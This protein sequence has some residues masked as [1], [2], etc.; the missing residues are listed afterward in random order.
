MLSRPNYNPDILSCLANLSSDEVFTPPR[1]VNEMLDLLPPEIWR[2][3]NVTFLDPVCKTGVFL[4]EIA[5]RLDVG[6]EKEIPDRQQRINHIFGKQLFGIGI[7]ELTT[8]LS[9]RSVYCSKTAN[10]KYSVCETFDDPRGNI[11]LERTEHIWENGRCAFCGASQQEY[12]RGN[13]LET[14]AY[15]F[16]HTETP[17]EIFRMKFDVIVG[18]P[19]YQL[20]DGG[21]QKSASPIYH[22]FVE[23]S[24]K[25]NPRY[26]SMI[27]PARWYAGGKGLD[28][29]R[30]TILND[31]RM[32]ILHDFPETSDC[33][34]GINIRGGVC[35]FLWEK[36][37]KGDCQIISH[38]GNEVTEPIKRPLLEKGSE[39]FI[40]YND[41]IP[42][43]RKVSEHQEDS[44]SKYVSAHKAFGLR[45]YVKGKEN[46]FDGSVK[47]YQNGGIGYIKREDVVKNTQWIDKWKIV[48]PYASPGSDVY[49]HQ[50]LSRPIVSEPGSCSTETYLV[51]GPFD[52]KKKCENVAAYMKTKFVRFLILLIKPSQHITQKTYQLVPVQ[53]FDTA[54]TDE[55]LFM[56]Y[57]IASD[58]IEFINSVIKPLV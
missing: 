16:I 1:L 58:E 12:D 55:K 42:I 33:F 39:V 41:A 54:W 25:L 44:F 45:T 8:L 18:N 48:V 57:G 15:Q 49:P 40:R 28:E 22:K 38:K 2:D 17:E 26:L 32:A 50:V 51:V 47:L 21:A 30:E 46:P 19:P 27:I 52:S 34:P 29:F 56:K 43:L 31:K 10:G 4:R 5:K 35:Y 7:T 20:S 24:K 23:Q 53:D 11:R 13:E 37:Y 3:R 6:L 14:H 36:D 9:R